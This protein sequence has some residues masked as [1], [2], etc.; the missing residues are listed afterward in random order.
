M[1]TPARHET[2]QQS[3]YQRIGAVLDIRA[4]RSETDLTRCVEARL[5]LRTVT[6]LFKCGLREDEIYALVIRGVR[7]LAAKAGASP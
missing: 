6:S 1:T 2:A 3:I 5:P 4:V 7:C